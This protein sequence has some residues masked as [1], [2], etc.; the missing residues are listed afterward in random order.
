MPD[1]AANSRMPVATIALPMRMVAPRVRRSSIDRLSRVF[2]GS[3]TRR[4]ASGDQEGRDRWPPLVCRA[5][6]GLSSP[7]AV[8]RD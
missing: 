6:L 1:K 2:F 8:E 3:F 5:A 7:A 4:G